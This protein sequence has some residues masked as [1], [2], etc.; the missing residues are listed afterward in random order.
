MRQVGVSLLL[1]A[2]AMSARADMAS[3][4]AP[5]ALPSGAKV[6]ARDD[7]GRTWRQSGVLQASVPVTR[8]AFSNTVARGGFV[9]RHVIPIGGKNGNVLEVWKRSDLQLMLMFWPVEGGKTM[10]SWGT[11]RE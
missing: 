10:F 6:V 9:C 5:F 7:S 4:N 11:F 8:Q 3:T 1:F 2:F